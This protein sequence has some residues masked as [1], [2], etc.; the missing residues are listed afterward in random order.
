MATWRIARQS[1]WKRVEAAGGFEHDQRDV[2]RPEAFDEGFEAFAVAR[3][4]KGLVRRPQV[5]VETI[6]GH[7][8]TDPN[9]N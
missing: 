4:G 6:L 3:D 1:G 5:H 7:I 9:R 2:E 8:D